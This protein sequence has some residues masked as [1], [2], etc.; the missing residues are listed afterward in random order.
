VWLASYSIGVEEDAGEVAF[1]VQLSETSAVPITIEYNLADV[2]ATREEDYTAESTNFV[3]VIPP[4]SQSVDLVYTIIDD[5]AVEPDES[6]FL[7]ITNAINARVGRA[8]LT[9]WIQD[10]DTYQPVNESLYAVTTP[11]SGMESNRTL[12]VLGSKSSAMELRGLAVDG[13]GNRYITDHA[14]GG[15][16]KGSIIVWPAGLDHIVRIVRGVTRPDDIELT[17]DGKRLVWVTGEGVIQTETLGVLIKLTGLDRENDST[18]L[19]YVQSD[20]GSRVAEWLPEG[21]YYARDILTEAQITHEI[22]ILVEYRGET[23]TFYRL[24]LV[25]ADIQTFDGLRLFTLDLSP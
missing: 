12:T 2:N 5:T 9:C 16:E 3:E 15:P 22:D 19:V 10:N 25:A 13:Q 6:F 4:G 8:E 23:R 7:E 18:A 17:P 24:S 20:S 11:G 14:S 21:Y 1:T